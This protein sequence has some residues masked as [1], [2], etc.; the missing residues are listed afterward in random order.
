MVSFSPQDKSLSNL[1]PV[2][3]DATSQDELATL[4]EQLLGVLGAAQP[5]DSDIEQLRLEARWLKEDLQQGVLAVPNDWELLLFEVARGHRPEFAKT[6][7][8]V[9]KAITQL[10]GCIDNQLADRVH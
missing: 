4:I 9:T 10:C 8:L 1:T 5:K 7:P 6:N 3:V 2:P